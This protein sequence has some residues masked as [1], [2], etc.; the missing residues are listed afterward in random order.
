MLAISA[1]EAIRQAVAA[2]GDAPAVVELA[3]PST[4]EQVY[5]AIEKLRRSEGASE[6]VAA[7]E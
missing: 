6:R 7:E 4:P 3:C 1:R 5:W 2:F